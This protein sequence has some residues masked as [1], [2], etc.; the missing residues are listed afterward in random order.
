MTYYIE[1]GLG[2]L[3][4]F[5]DG[6]FFNHETRLDNE[7][8]FMANGSSGIAYGSTGPTLGSNLP[9]IVPHSP[10][11]EFTYDSLIRPGGFGDSVEFAFN[12]DSVVISGI[13]DNI[14]TGAS[15]GEQ[16]LYSVEGFYW[17]G[18]IY[19]DYANVVVNDQNALARTFF[20]VGGYGGDTLEI[21]GFFESLD[22]VLSE[23]LGAN[24]NWAPN[25][26]HGDGG[27]P[28]RPDYDSEVDTHMSYVDTLVI[29]DLSTNGYS[30]TYQEVLG[31]IFGAEQPTNVDTVFK[32]QKGDT[33]YL[34]VDV[35]IVQFEDVLFDRN[36]FLLAESEEGDEVVGSNESEYL[37]GYIGDDD[38]SGGGGDDFLNG[39]EGNDYLYSGDGND[40]VNAGEGDDVIIGGDGRGDDQ[41]IGGE[42]LD[43]I[44]YSSSLDS[45]VEVSLRLGT[46]EGAEIGSDILAGIENVTL[47]QSC[48]FI[49]GDAQNNQIDGQEGL[50][51]AIFQGQFDEYSI[52][53][54]IDGDF[55]VTDYVP[56]RDGID[57]LS[58][59]EILTFSDRDVSLVDGVESLAC[60]AP[61]QD[62]EPITRPVPVTEPPTAINL[63][64]QSIDENIEY[65][66]VVATIS[67]E[68]ADS[69]SHTY[70]LLYDRG[71]SD[72]WYFEISA[73]QL[74]LWDS[75][76][77]ESKPFYLIGLQATDESGLTYQQEIELMVNDV[78]E[79][80]SDLF[81]V[82][83]SFDENI[84]VGSEVSVLSSV[85][86]DLGD[87]VTYAL[88]NGDGG[89]D[90]D[91][92]AVS[93]SSLE[94]LVS[95]DF[96]IKSN[97]S[98]RLEAIDDAGLSLEKS[99]TLYVNDLDE[100]PVAEPMPEPTAEPVAVVEPTP[101]PT[102]EP[103]PIVEPTPEP[104]AEQ[105]PVESIN[106]IVEL[107]EVSRFELADPVLVRD[108]QIDTLI[109]GTEGKDKITGTS[110]SEILLAGD[111][112]DS[113]KGGGGVDGF[114][115][116]KPASFTKKQV[117]RIN[118]FNSEEGDAI[119]LDR[120][121]FGLGR[122]FRLETV[123]G[124]KSVNQAKEAKMQFVYDDKKGRLYFNENGKDEGWGEGGLFLRIK[125][126]PE[127]LQSDLVLF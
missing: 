64:V 34:A 86:D 59:I 120:D 69:D 105:M 52:E 25:M 41:Y 24:D 127:L 33:E 61:S 108:E 50:D 73:D 90:N 83:W 7:L 17:E 109:V 100:V 57:T 103:V 96:G 45:P 55:I 42:G 60:Q 117:D 97:Y 74:L 110:A 5:R 124:K 63:S 75:P 111:G 48:D 112:K 72:S 123:T 125:G 37:G 122:R 30:I 29:D 18:S 43:S 58:S 20:Y 87:V 9:E 115:F 28:E 49:E 39:M 38:L 118:D 40:T 3:N 46:A 16:T 93:G 91:L 95:P 67:A 4:E 54:T 94:I 85:D 81:V 27:D 36:S 31:G 76:D 53:E 2:N 114:L 119:L 14:H 88:V 121:S 44:V 35:E 106:E 15:S 89:E 80:P 47:G 84:A 56:N 101:E 116:Q 113:L 65:G 79:S 71:D 104:T 6:W 19:D 12:S 26:F 102:A 92:F 78:N 23:S 11:G 68:D 99:F 8:L 21:T 10:F 77:Y 1:D 82:P 107:D 126:A 98:I 51:T 13:A 70:E 62:S 66:S 32:I 22:G